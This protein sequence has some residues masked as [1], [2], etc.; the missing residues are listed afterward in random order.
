[1]KYT[2]ELLMKEVGCAKYPERWSEIFDVAMREYDEKG[3]YLT[4]PQFYDALHEKY[5]CFAKYGDVYKAAAAETASDEALARFL[6][7]LAMSLQD[8]EHRRDD[9][10]AFER[11]VTPEGK[12]PLA[13]E[14]VTGL[15]LCSQLERGAQN[16]K[17]RNFSDELI[18][19]MLTKAIDG[20][21]TYERK[22]N[23]AY[24]FELLSWS[25]LFIE[26]K[27][28]LIERLQIEFLSGFSGRA[29]VFKN[30]KGEVEVLAHDILL[31]RDGFALGSLHFEDEEG[32]WSANV[33]ETENAW[34]G[35]PFRADGYVDKE[36]LELPKSDWE[37]VLQRHDPVI[38][39]HIPAKGKMTPEMIDRTLEA[40]KKF[41]AKH[42]PEYDYKAFA[43]N[44][45]LIDPQLD[46]LLDKESNIVKFR[47]RFRSLNHK[48]AGK[49]IFNFIFNKAD[50]NFELQDLP[51]DTSLQRGL[52]KHYMDGKAIYEM[53]G[54]FF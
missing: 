6:T 37:K 20:V 35:H 54:F 49:G 46:E 31:H 48:S 27:L 29:I 39:L 18:T 45:W 2:L 32:A 8:E 44:S 33:E 41:A 22:H 52:K 12:E 51:E 50:M 17:N 40:T 15:A 47:Q 7:L 9:I 28:A 10:K 13:Y 36:K 21:S 43:C 3:C 19:E 5:G 34:I 11:P 24:G 4:D 42:Y 23:G 14:M 1:M 25:Q 38:R 26:A 16:M 53:E 30:R